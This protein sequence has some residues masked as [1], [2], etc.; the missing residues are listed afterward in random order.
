MHSSYKA[1]RVGSSPTTRT[2]LIAGVNM[3]VDDKQYEKE[4]ARVFWAFVASFAAASGL[5]LYLGYIA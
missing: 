3:F 1:E 4:A 2:N 5:I